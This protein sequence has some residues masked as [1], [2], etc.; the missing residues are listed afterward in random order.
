[1]ASSTHILLPP[2]ALGPKDL[3]LIINDDDPQSREVGEYYQKAR[4]I[5]AANVIHVKFPPGRSALGKE[6]FARIKA[7]ID[8]ATP[9]HVQAYAVSWTK[10]YRAGC[11]SITSALALGL[12]E[13]YCSA[14][15]GP[16][17]ASPYFNSDSTAPATDHRLR[18]AMMLAGTGFEQVKAL[19]D[20]GVAADQR[21]PAGRAYLLSTP[22]RARNVR[23]LMFGQTAKQLGG[24]FDIELQKGSSLGERRDV[25]FYFTGL[26]QVPDLNALAFLPGALADHLT[27]F[28][29]QLTDSSQMSILRWLE[30]GAT[31]SYGTVL[32]PCSHPQKFPLP[33]VAMYHYANG[34]SAIEAYWKSV[35][36]PG[37]GVFVGEPLAQPFAP[38]VTEVQ[39]DQFE[40]R[41]YSGRD[42]WLRM[43]QSNSPMGPFKALPKRQPI[44]RGANLLRFSAPGLGDNYLRLLW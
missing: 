42:R 24:V 5:P 37:E 23:A 18:P 43:E 41:I 6:E 35:Q 13:S 25:M 12:D 8:A 14:K 16:T 30:A 1:M 44:R 27:S 26:A 39:P 32:E 40:L 9:D 15:C 29:G 11:M 22:D 34:A 21:F 17:K 33:A 3:A 19:I 10:P 7:E 31:A 38:S 2:T 20:R 36:W 28:G 4:R